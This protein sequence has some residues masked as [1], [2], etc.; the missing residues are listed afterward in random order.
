[1]KY[2]IKESGDGLE[3]SVSGIQDKKEK[4][5]QSFQA[6]SEGRC[7]CRTDEYKKLQSMEIEH[8]ADGIKLKLKSRA[9]EKFDPSEINKCLIETEKNISE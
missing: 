1:M 4:L 9:G 3:I 8:S 2:D 7:S 5:M 6:C